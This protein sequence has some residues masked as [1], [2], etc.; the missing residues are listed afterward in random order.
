MKNKVLFLVCEL[1]SAKYCF[2]L[3]KLLREEK[4]SFE[5]KILAFGRINLNDLSEFADYLIPNYDGSKTFEKNLI[6]LNWNPD[7]IFSSAMKS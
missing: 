5:W 3:W 7:L 2:P 4:N 1:G 6:S